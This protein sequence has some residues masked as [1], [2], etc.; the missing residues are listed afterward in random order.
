VHLR[1]HAQPPEAL[2]HCLRGPG[3][4][5]E[6][7]FHCCSVCCY[8]QMR[9]ALLFLLPRSAELKPPRLFSRCPYHG[10]PSP[11]ART[12]LSRDG[13]VRLR[14]FGRPQFEVDDFPAGFFR[15]R[16]WLM[17]RP[18][19][20]SSRALGSRDVFVPPATPPRLAS[21]PCVVRRYF[22][23]SPTTYESP[24]F[25]FRSSLILRPFP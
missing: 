20:V 18:L 3:K 19:S 16:C 15:T 5:K 12:S 7:H 11:E 8:P 2:A 4:M 22:R 9:C 21:T 13:I 25:F 14:P 6:R 1:R 10:Y 17:F 23:V 24:V